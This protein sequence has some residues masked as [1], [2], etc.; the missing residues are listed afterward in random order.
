MTESTEVPAE[1]AEQ[2]EYPPEPEPE[3]PDD[4][5]DRSA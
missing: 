2:E 4:G 5:Q 1:P 3:W